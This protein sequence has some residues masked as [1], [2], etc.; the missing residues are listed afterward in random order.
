[1]RLR[2]KVTALALATTLAALLVSGVALLYYDARG[3]REGRLHDVRTKAEILA[4]ASAAAL[5]FQDVKEAQAT[6][7]TLKAL[8]T[9]GAAALYA[10]S[11]EPVAA[12]REAGFEVPARAPSPGSSIEGE[13]ILFTHPI[14]E[15][16][17][18]I[19]VLYID[20]YY[21]LRDRIEYYLGILG[22]ALLLALGAAYVLSLWLQRAVT[23]PIL[24]VADA[25]RDVVEKA[26]Y[27]VRA[28]RPAEYETRLLAD[29]FNQMLE[30]IARRAAELG[31][32]EERFR[33]IANSAPVLIWMN[34]ESGAVFVNKAYLD[35]IG[36]ER[37]VDVRG[38]DWTQFVHPEDREGYVHAY[39]GAVRANLLF[40]AE[41][42]FRRRDGEYRWMRSVGAPRL[43]PAGERLGYTGCTFDVHDA[44]VAADALIL[45]DRRKDEFLATLAHELRN[46]LAPLLMCVNLLR[47]TGSA[48]PNEVW[49]R[50]VIERQ[51][52]HMSR[53]LDDLLDVGRITNNK[54]ELRRQRVSFASVIEAAVET[55]RPLIAKAGHR[56]ELALPPGEVFVDGDPV[57]LAQVFS[58]LLNNAARYTDAG[59]EIR[60]AAELAAGRLVVTVKDNGMGIAAEDMPSLFGIFSQSRTALHRAQ[61]GLGIGLFLVKSLVEMHGGSVSAHS[62]G[63]GKGTAFTVTLPASASRVAQPQEP[64][65]AVKPGALRVLVAD[66]NEDA[67]ESLAAVLRVAGHDVRVAHDGQEA[68]ELAAT[69]RPALA[70]LDIGMPR[71]NGYEAAQRIRGQEGGAGLLLIAVTGWGQQDDRRRAFEAGFDHHLTKPAQLEDIEVLMAKVRRRAA[72]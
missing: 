26:D 29:A 67:A 65:S 56:F 72:R 4:R 3:Y 42:R 66:D 10:A 63:P 44:R 61:G 50:D 39:L 47:R 9:V 8:P 17:D 49:A 54:L 7:D 69:F 28:P 53:L 55:S 45:A 46:P 51:V 6:V 18:T 59:G 27:T 13:R 21:G 36:V 24:A 30:E 60:L 5:A 16:G 15:G 22:G 32:S 41:F 71:M 14:V 43:T 64:R 70:L 33:T 57:R 31:E 1:V 48:E 20:A 52:R 34:D 11:G 37:Q 35:F 23:Q 40:E 38:F 25:A 19:G 12:Y 58:N 2:H 62:D 68:V